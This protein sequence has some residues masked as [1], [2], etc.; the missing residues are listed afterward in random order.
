M[1]KDRLALTASIMD[2]TL[3]LSTLMKQGVVADSLALH[4]ANQASDLTT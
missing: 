2:Q 3:T 4:D 1:S